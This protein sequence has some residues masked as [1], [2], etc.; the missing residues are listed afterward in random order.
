M[1]TEPQHPSWGPST[2]AVWGGEPA[3]NAEGVTVTPVFHGVTF[4]YDDLAAWRAVSLGEA[5]GYIYSRNT[6]PTVDVFEAKMR[7]LEA[8]EDSTSF[9]T[10]MAAISNTLFTLLKPGDRVVSIKDTYGGTN[11][12][13][14]EFLPRFG[15]EATICDTEDHEA[16]EREVA[17]GC[18]VLYL[19]SPTNPTLK[20]LDIARLAHAAHA[21]GA[22]VVVDNTFATP[23]NQNPLAL[24]AD[25]VLHSA[26]KFLG[27]HSD[28]MGG[29]VC[30]PARLVRPIYHFREITGATLDPMS[31]FLLTR[32]IRTLELRVERQNSNAQRVAEF[33]AGH[34]AIETVFYPGLPG[35]RGHEI[36][37]RQMR[38]FGGVLAFSLK[39]GYAA[40][41]RMVDALTL[42]HRA[43]SLG[44]VGTLVGPPA[45]TSHVELSAE[46]RAAAGIPEGLVR[47]AVGIE[48]ADDLIADLR[49]A[50]AVLEQ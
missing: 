33:L 26:T 44:S 41:E 15:I 19:E 3:R 5:P 14:T 9:S 17:A 12:L 30:G 27:G 43:A 50:L 22:T 39:G 2:R 32:G 46:E 34:P 16:I 42:A 13:F 36:A 25:L 7:A 1:S 45:V 4:E 6:N 23:I 40:M 38:G 21:V 28:A 24:G 8:A 37:R 47:Y 48:N 11:L 31:A 10:G 29:V 18:T 49:A 35:H 20:V